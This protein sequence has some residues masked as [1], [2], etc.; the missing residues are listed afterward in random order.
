[1]RHVYPQLE[2]PLDRIVLFLTSVPSRS[3]RNV[4]VGTGKKDISAPCGRR[5][6]FSE[7]S[8]GIMSFGERGISG[9]GCVTDCVD[10]VISRNSHGATVAAVDGDI[11]VM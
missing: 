11:F 8:L 1:M 4:P 9:K 6:E 2:H 5:R 10:C 7:N 3:G